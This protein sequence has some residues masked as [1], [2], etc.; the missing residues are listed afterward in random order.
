MNA[1]RLVGLFTIGISCTAIS[2]CVNPSEKIAAGL[3]RYG[4]DQA[5][6]QCMGDRLEV[7]LSIDQLQQLGRA[8]RAVNE[9]D[10]TPGRLTPSDFIRVSAQLKD[11]RVPLEVTK[12]AAGCGV[13]A[14]AVSVL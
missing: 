7:N 5:Q 11:A 4:L 1:N 9:D 10:L 13:L 2:A 8:A 14:G 3:T 6:A 12:A